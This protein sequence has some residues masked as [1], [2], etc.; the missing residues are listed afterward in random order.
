MDTPLPRLSAHQARVL[1]C[2]IEKEAT[3]PDVYPLTV[4]AA[5]AAANQKTAREPVMHLDPGE[6]QH[7]LRQLEQAGLAK[8]HFS[9][10]AERYAHLADGALGLVRPQVI[11]LGLLL[12]RGPQTAYELLARSERMSRFEDIDDV[13]HHLERLAQRSPP[14]VTQLPRG[15]GQRED[16]YAHLLC[17]PVSVEAT[18]VTRDDDAPVRERADETALEARVATLEAEVAELR[19]R[20]QSLLPPEPAP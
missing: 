6:V 8:Q 11:L 9:S 4:N 15:G 20:L 5:Q 2:L 12:L 19:T 17:G 7:A 3:T 10:R 1:G 14:L 16:R 18:A 13:R